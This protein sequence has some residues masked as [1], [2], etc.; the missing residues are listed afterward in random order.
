MINRTSQLVYLIVL[1]ISASCS[2][3]V[4]QFVNSE[5]SFTT[6]KSFGITNLKSTNNLSPEG[7]EV[8]SFI[9]NQINEELTRRDYVMNNEDPDIVVRYELIAN[10]RNEVNPSYNTFNPTFPTYRYSF[11]TVL[12]SALLMELFDAGNKKLIWQASLDLKKQSGKTTR[13]EILKDAV[14]KLFNTYLYRA[15][16]K[17][18]DQSLVVE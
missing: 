18:T 15:E 10:Q 4:I 13:E 7:K 8:Y 6:Y 5:S 17:I 1:L 2:P 9:E 14:T 11:R 12:E 3:K 16:S